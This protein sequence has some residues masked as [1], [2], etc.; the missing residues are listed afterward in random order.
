MEINKEELINNLPV[1]WKDITLQQYIT[2]VELTPKNSPESIN[3]STSALELASS[4]I[5]TFTGYNMQDLKLNTDN[6][7][8]VIRKTIELN[9]DEAKTIEVD[10]KEIKTIDEIDFDSFIKFLKFQEMNSFSVYPQMISLMLKSPVSPSDILNWDMQKV[11]SFF[12]RLLEILN[13]YLEAS[14]AFLMQKMK[15]I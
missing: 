4:Y 12:L 13:Q 14:Q 11:N 1:K 10:D 2:L 6:I 9:N 15:L 3:E 8:L 7:V 5:Y